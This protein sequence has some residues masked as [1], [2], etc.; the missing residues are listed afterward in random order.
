MSCQIFTTFTVR[1]RS[2]RTFT[3]RKNTEAIAAMRSRQ[4]YRNELYSSSK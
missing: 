1:K 4:D 3:D 2:A